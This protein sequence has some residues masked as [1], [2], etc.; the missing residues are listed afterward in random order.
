[1]QW[2]LSRP[3]E[4]APLFDY[5]GKHWVPDSFTQRYDRHVRR[6]ALDPKVNFHALRH[7]YATLGLSLA[8]DIKTI[9]AAL[10]HSQIGI[11]ANTYL[12][13]TRALTDEAADRLNSVF[14]QRRA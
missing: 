9:S 2:G 11:T 1:M 6:S 10:G 14:S 4:D 12:H 5:Y 3:T 8:L 13:V 7:S